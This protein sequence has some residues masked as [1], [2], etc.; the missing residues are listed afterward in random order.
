MVVAVAVGGLAHPHQDRPACYFIG[1]E[2]GESDAQGSSRTA[3][4]EQHFKAE[5]NHNFDAEQKK[6]PKKWWKD[7]PSSSRWQAAER[8]KAEQQEHFNAEQKKNFDAEQKK[9]F[10]EL[11]S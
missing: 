11:V 4:A 3:E 7:P 6:P 10:A 5:Q 1:S 9:N 8:A 2:G